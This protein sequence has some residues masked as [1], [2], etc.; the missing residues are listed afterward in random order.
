MHGDCFLLQWQYNPDKET[1]PIVIQ[2]VVEDEGERRAVGKIHKK[3]FTRN[4][5]V[6]LV[7]GCNVLKDR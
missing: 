6:W 4:W 7:F 1:I 5:Q 3:N 2:C